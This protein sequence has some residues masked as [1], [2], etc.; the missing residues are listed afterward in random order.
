[1]NRLSAY[2]FGLIPQYTERP[3]TWETRQDKY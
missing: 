1:L 2:S 3:A